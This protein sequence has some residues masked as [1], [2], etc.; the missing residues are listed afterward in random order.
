MSTELSSVRAALE[1]RML[2]ERAKGLLMVQQGISEEAAYGLLRQKAM[3][4]HLKITE[5]ANSLLAIADFFPTRP[6]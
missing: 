1:D 4:Q 6:N 2:I 5:V 3:S